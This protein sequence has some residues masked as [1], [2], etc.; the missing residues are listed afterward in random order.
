MANRDLIIPDQLEFAF[1]FRDEINDYEQGDIVVQYSR[2]YD[3]N[4][5]GTTA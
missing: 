5:D 3:A 1:Q 2:F 4:T